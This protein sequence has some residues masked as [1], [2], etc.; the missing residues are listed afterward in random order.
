MKWTAAQQVPQLIGLNK[1]TF[2]PNGN[3]NDCVYHQRRGQTICS[4][5]RK[6]VCL[7]RGKRNVFFCPRRTR[8]NPL[9]SFRHARKSFFGTALRASF[10]HMQ[11][12]RRFHFGMGVILERDERERHVSF[13]REKKKGRLRPIQEALAM[14]ATRVVLKEIPT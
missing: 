6:V 7:V 11:V 3:A 8:R 4:R 9:N 1:T 10:V 14:S 5:L 13:R 2:S 12:K